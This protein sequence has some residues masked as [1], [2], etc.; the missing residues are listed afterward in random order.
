MPRLIGTAGH[1]DHG[2]T[3]LIHALTGIDADRLP[4]EKARGMTID[5]G[6][7]HIDLPGLGEVSIV[8][9]PGHEKFLRNMLVG[10]HGIDVALLCVAADES[11]MAQTREHFAI[12]E[13]LPVAQMVVA[14]TKCDRAEPEL[15]DASRDDIRSLLADTRF[16]GSPIIEVSAIQGSGID[17]L[18]A[19]LIEAVGK[20]APR[21]PSEWS[22]PIDR[23]FSVKGFGT[24]VTGTLGGGVLTREAAA[25]LMPSGQT[26]RIRGLE[27]HGVAVDH[28]EPGQRVGINLGGI[29]LADVER[30]QLLASP[31]TAFGTRR[32]EIALSTPWTAKARERIRLSVGATEAIGRVRQVPDDDTRLI[33]ELESEI[34][35]VKGQSVI[36]RRY[37]PPDLLGGGV[38]SVPIAQGIQARAAST[39]VELVAQFPNGVSTDDICRRLGSTPQKLGDDFERE[40]KSGALLGFA[41]LWI[42][43][44]NYQEATGRLVHS[45]SLLHAAQPTVAL[46][47]IGPVLEATE[48][49]WS[50]KPLERILADLKNRGT[51]RGE[52]MKVACSEFVVELSPKQRQFLDRLLAVMAAGGLNAANLPDLAKALPAP[53]QA[54]EEIVKLGLATGELVRVDT[55]LWTRSVVQTARETLLQRFA[56]APF[57]AAEAR[58]ALQTSRKYI[59]PLLEHFDA[60]GFTVRRGE[61]RLIVER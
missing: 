27:V 42:T 55:I 52:G 15:R 8:D 36:L 10:A 25:E 32:V 16:E 47:S 24:V 34:G 14:L 44:E 17:D 18:R 37:S 23:A 3:T 60:I 48:L 58:D 9:V 4:E 51:L 46:Q 45:L 53:V 6:F 11:V 21:P 22:L 57:S 30:G 12:L 13:R 26:A 40:R 41:G 54:V 7:A 39:L 5:L 49:P 50:G 19:A 31:G 28:A 43:P 2:K 35:V 61:T 20:S 33:V 38:V 29:D 59:I 1:V 56:S